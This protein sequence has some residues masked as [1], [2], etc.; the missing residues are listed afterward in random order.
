MFTLQSHKTKALEVFKTIIDTFSTK[1]VT[2]SS[3]L[4]NKAACV[5]CCVLEN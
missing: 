3:Q 2:F 5:S 4:I 1:K